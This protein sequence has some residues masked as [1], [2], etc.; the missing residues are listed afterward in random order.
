MK[1]PTTVVLIFIGMIFL[2]GMV[3]GVKWCAPP[4]PVSDE[5]VASDTI[6]VEV[7]VQDTIYIPIKEQIDDTTFTFEY[8]DNEIT[9]RGR[10][11]GV[12]I[13]GLE[14]SS[15][16]YTGRADVRIYSDRIEATPR[17][18]RLKIHFQDFQTRPTPKERLV[19]AEVIVG[20]PMTLNGW[21]AGLGL[22]MQ[23]IPFSRKRADI[24]SGLWV[25][26]VDKVMYPGLYVRIGL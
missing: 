15:V 10:C 11:F 3:V 1:I 18:D 19:G 21:M 8:S 22:Q 16:Q 25:A 6:I 7:M 2:V 13:T 12:A 5:P 23:R 14:I 26:Q 4:V 17:T 20:G 24:S 9:V